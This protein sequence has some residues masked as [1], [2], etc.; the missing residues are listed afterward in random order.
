ML[1]FGRQTLC[2]ECGVCRLLRPTTRQRR[3]SELQPDL[4]YGLLLLRLPP[5]RQYGQAAVPF[6]CT[7]CGFCRV[8]GRANFVHC[9]TCQLCLA[10]GRPHVCRADSGHNAC[11]LCYE[12]IFTSRLAAHIPPCGHLLHL[13]CYIKMTRKVRLNIKQL[14]FSL[15]VCLIR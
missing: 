11:P 10:A 5:L 9:A 4:R 2:T 8:G 1:A 12:D 13:P 14:N 6:H 3:L 7:D 15:I